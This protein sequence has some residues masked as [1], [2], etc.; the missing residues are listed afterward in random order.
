MSIVVGGGSTVVSIVSACISA[1]SSL[2][3][4]YGGDSVCGRRIGW[5]TAGFSVVGLVSSLFRTTSSSSSCAGTSFGLSGRYGSSR[6]IGG[7]GI[8][9]MAQSYGGNSMDLASPHTVNCLCCRCC[10][11]EILRSAKCVNW[12]ECVNTYGN[13]KMHENYC[14]WDRH[15]DRRL[16]FVFALE[17]RMMMRNTISKIT[18]WDMK[19]SSEFT[20]VP[21]W[22]RKEFSSCVFV[23]WTTFPCLLRC[24][25]W[26]FGSEKRFSCSVWRYVQVCVCARVDSWSESN[27]YFLNL[28]VTKQMCFCFVCIQ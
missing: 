27:I 1:M 28:N 6:S 20:D 11:C 7:G 8:N 18:M 2:G 23:N 5:L 10:C 19:S 4:A 26:R 21:N 9:G 25:I 24:I 16:F 15:G 14:N 13:Q 17:I 22:T 12:M 3:T